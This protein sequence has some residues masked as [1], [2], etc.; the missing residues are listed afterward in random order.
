MSLKSKRTRRLVKAPK[1]KVGRQLLAGYII[2][3]MLI[4]CE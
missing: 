1:E 4:Y 2:I 3:P